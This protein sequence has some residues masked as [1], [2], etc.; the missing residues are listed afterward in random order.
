MNN[1]PQTPFLEIPVN[2]RFFQRKNPAV[3]NC[4]KQFLLSDSFFASLDDHFFKEFPV[5]RRHILQ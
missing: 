4:I 5:Y 1:Y 3:V 2:S